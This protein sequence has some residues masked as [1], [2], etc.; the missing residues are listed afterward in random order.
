MKIFS[1]RNPNESCARPWRECL[2]TDY[3]QVEQFRSRPLV[4]FNNQPII[5]QHNVTY[6]TGKDT[7]HAHHVAKMIASAVLRGAYDKAPALTVDAGD[8]PATVLWIDSVRG[9]HAS[10]DFYREMTAGLQPGDKRFA[11]LCLDTLGDYRLNFWEL[12]REIE[13]YIRELQPTLVVIDDVD[14]L[15]PNCG[16]KLAAEF[17]N[18][19]R[20]T[21]NYTPAAFLMVGYNHLAKKASTTG[22]LGKALFPCSNHVYSVTTQH[23]VSR[24]R[25]VRSFNVGMHIM[26][27][28]DSDLLFTVGADNFPCEVVDARCPAVSDAAGSS[29]DAGHPQP[30]PRGFVSQTVLRDIFTQLI[31]PGQ[32]MSPDDLTAALTARR[33]QLNRI[34]RSRILIAQALNLGILE[35]TGPDGTPAFY[36]LKQPATPTQPA[37][38]AT[39]LTIH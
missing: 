17:H 34:D 27:H 7:C 15:M 30:L 1:Y 37:Q 14:H 6:V 4:S 11:L 28:P 25:L 26:D 22:Q 13:A 23:A 9:P 18:I 33:Q 24:V 29:D 20:D 35:K 12:T 19:V 8:K 2:I 39:P 36:T 38:P 5:Q 21:C 3:S 10:A 16:M 31:P 32:S